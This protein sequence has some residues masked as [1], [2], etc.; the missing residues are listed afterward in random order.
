MRDLEKAALAACDAV[1]VSSDIGYSKPDMRFF[2]GIEERLGVDK[3]L[4]GRPATDVLEIDHLQFASGAEEAEAVAG[5]H[6]RHAPGARRGDVGGL[7]QHVAVADLDQAA[8]GG[9]DGDV[10][11]EDVVADVLRAR[12]GG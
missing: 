1:F 5:A 10:G 3:K 6:L 8:F 7:A 2:R 4:R 12:A 9:P 11:V